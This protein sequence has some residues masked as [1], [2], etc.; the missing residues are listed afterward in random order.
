[1]SAR[2][3]RT[4][5]ISRIARKLARHWKK[6]REKGLDARG[7]LT[8]KVPLA[9]RERNSRPRKLIAYDFE[10]TKIAEGTPSPLYLTAFTDG[11]SAS[12][13]VQS[14]DHLA[15]VLESRF[16]T[17]ENNR[18]R[19]VAWNG[20]GFDVYFIARAL[21]S[22]PQYELR[23]YLTRG[24][25]C[26]GL[27]V[28]VKPEYVAQA[29][30]GFIPGKR[31][32]APKSLSWEFL[33]G[34]AMTVGNAPV[35][36]RQFLKVFAPEY[37]KL[38]GPDFDAGEV[39]DPKNPE[40]VRYAE[41]DSEGLY[42][43][44]MEAQTIVQQHFNVPLQPTVGNMAIRIFQANMPK[45]IQCWEPIVKV[46][47]VIRTQV[48]RGG[49]CHC[50]RAYE[51]PI[52][53]YDLN[54]A[55]AAAMR[56]ARLPAGRMAHLR[57]FSQYFRAAIYR[58]SARHP[59]G[60]VVPFYYIDI[61]GAAQFSDSV[62]TDTWVTSIEWT[63]LRD[64]G[65]IIDTR[66]GYGWEETFS[67]KDYVA[68]LE[69]LRTSAPD[70]PSGA[71]GTMVKSVGN[72][73]Y[74]KTVEMLDGMEFLF[75]YDKPKDFHPYHGD[76][77]QMENVWFRFKEPQW[78]EYHQPQLGAFITAHVRMLVRRAALLAPQNFL[79]ADTDCVVFDRPVSLP[80]DRLKYGFW[81]VEEAGERYWIITKKVYAKIEGS[82]DAKHA[83]HAKGMNVK[84]LTKADFAA[85]AKGVAPRQRQLQR[86]NFVN[87]VTGGEMFKSR[88]KV[89]QK[90][91]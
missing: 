82:W 41:R 27:K 44:M 9:R 91:A 32:K 26:R 58:I 13:A 61:T 39:F 36:L 89:G 45:G 84:R 63:Q 18:S 62:I 23:P 57:R 49:Y 6:L 2:T 15:S 7:Q 75:A 68:K 85:W 73:S 31:R 83:R 11:W 48:M 28:S 46:S 25:T 87:F 16:L 3:E 53:K 42:H 22:L 81:K 76:E 51:G 77:T 56:D 40:H 47:D 71:L 20:N 12:L 29:L 34:M 5:R 59:R 33:D 43:A 24:K 52:W 64:E 4:A 86:N 54:Q 66:E 21:L 30:V 1:M 70:G 74:G 65:W 35:S 78:R 60:T 10:T 79:Y 19:F 14:F 8:G 69:H 17:A 80:V 67:M 50:Q 90:F 88:E 37:E 55:Y 72:N 38:Q